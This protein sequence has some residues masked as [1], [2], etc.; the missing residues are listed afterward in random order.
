MRPLLRLGLLAAA[1]C[2]V[3][4]STIPDKGSPGKVEELLNETTRARSFR[5]DGMTVLVTHD[6][7]PFPPYEAEVRGLPRDWGGRLGFVMIS[8]EPRFKECRQ[9]ELLADDTSVPV[10]DIEYQN[11]LGSEAWFEG[12]WID[13]NAKSLGKMAGAKTAGARF[14]DAELFLDD[15]Q[16][17]VFRS[18]VSR[19]VR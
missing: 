15:E 19:V 16:M 7:K 5:L 17:K 13:V 3:G 10:R 9:I 11:T 4:C 12:Y 18:F 1:F 14:C 6:G 2:A 8:P